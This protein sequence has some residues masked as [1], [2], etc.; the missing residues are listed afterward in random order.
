MKDVPSFCSHTS[1]TKADLLACEKAH[2][3][4]HL[5]PGEVLVLLALTGATTFFALQPAPTAFAPPA[6][7]SEPDRVAARDEARP[8]W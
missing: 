4:R 2:A 1:P 3:A 5:S 7:V 8:P 6:A